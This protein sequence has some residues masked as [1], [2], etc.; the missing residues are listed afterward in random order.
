VL[1][2]ADGGGADLVFGDFGG[3][4]EGVDCEHVGGAFA[5]MEG[6]EEPAGL[7]SVGDLCRGGYPA[8]AG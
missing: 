1:Y 3:W 8:A 7:D 2:L 4:V 6:H 5:E